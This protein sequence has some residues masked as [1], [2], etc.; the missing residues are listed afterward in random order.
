MRLFVLLSLFA[1]VGCQDDQNTA[2]ATTRYIHKYGFDISK[3]EWESRKQD[4]FIIS[5]LDNQAVKKASYVNG[6]LQGH[7]TY[8]YPSSSII[9]K[10]EEYD[11]G[12]LLKTVYNDLEGNP[13]KEELLEFDNRKIITLWDKQ[14]V[15][16]S[17]EE[18][19]NNIL[20]KGD[21]FTQKHEKEAFIENGAG[22]RMKRSRDGQLLCK[23]QIENGLVVH[24]MTYHPNGNIQST[25]SFDNYVLNGEQKTYSPDGNLLTEMMWNHGNPDGMKIVYRNN[26]VVLKVPYVNGKRHGL[27]KAWDDDGR[28][29]T[30]IQWQDDIRH[31]SSRYYG[32]EDTQIDWYYLGKAV[33]QQQYRMM[34]F[35]E[36]MVA[37]LQEND[38][39][40]EK[41]YIR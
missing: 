33:S 40:T 3:E 14:G 20:V 19:Q 23:D 32:K 24:R 10:I 35:R 4:G 30:R 8:T 26:K 5:Q 13:F 9:S 21:Y 16:M 38:Y 12:N 36:K 31:G 7:T 41:G 27:E 17:V 6:V 37:E 18:Y 39:K 2:V 22:T 25:A 11:D 15:P 1:L 34:E 28:L 29:I